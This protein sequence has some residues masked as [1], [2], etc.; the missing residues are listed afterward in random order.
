MQKSCLLVTMALNAIGAMFVRGIHHILSPKTPEEGYHLSVDSINKSIL[1]L[2][3]H[4]SVL[5]DISSQ[6]R[7]HLVA[8]I[9]KL[10]TTNGENDAQDY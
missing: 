5:R 4:E 7:V 9:S 10:P 8:A 6:Q 3:S 1:F 2:S